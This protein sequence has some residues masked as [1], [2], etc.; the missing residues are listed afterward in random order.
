VRA[1]LE[2]NSFALAGWKVMS[3]LCEPSLPPPADAL[4]RHRA[5]ERARVTAR[6]AVQAVAASSS[7]R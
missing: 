2:K 3:E 6:L 7:A 1:V 5:A 4:A